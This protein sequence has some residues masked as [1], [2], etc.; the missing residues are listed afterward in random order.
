MLLYHFLLVALFFAGSVNSLPVNIS[1]S[2]EP[3]VIG[4]RDYIPPLGM[5]DESGNPSGFNVELAEALFDYLDIEYEIKV[6]VIDQL[7]R[8]FKDDKLDLIFGVVNSKE[9]EGYMMFGVPYYMMS[10]TIISRCEDSYR[11][12]SELRDKKIFVQNKSWIHDYLKKTEYV[13]NI[14]ILPIDESLDLLAAGEGDAVISNSPGSFQLFAERDDGEYDGLSLF[15]VD[16]EPQKYSFAVHSEDKALLDLINTALYELDKSGVVDQLYTKWFGVS[17]EEGIPRIAWIIIVS[18]VVGLIIVITFLVL[19]RHQVERAIAKWEQLN[20]ELTVLKE[21]A[22]KENRMKS[23]FLANIS[24]DIRSPL[25]SIVGFSELLSE[26]DDYNERMRYF[27]I[28][29]DSNDLIIQLIND[30]LDLAKIE[31]GTMEFNFTDVNLNNLLEDFESCSRIKVGNKKINIR[32]EKEQTQLVIS[33]DK[34]R[35]IQV[36][37]NLMS[38][39]IKNTETG[40]ITFGYELKNDSV[41]YY[42]S[43]TGVGIPVDKIG[44]IFERYTKLDNFQQGSGLGLSICYNIVKWF[45]G[46]IGVD[47][48]PGKGSVFWFTIPFSKSPVI[49]CEKINTN[50]S[51]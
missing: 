44:L 27:Q 39:A 11:K 46:E 9:R 34:N 25:N 10:W 35:L 19:L 24:H 45:D 21:K 14:I 49:K 32:F 43:D 2:S 22:E 1:D 5:L 15:N 7:L 16:L 26:S 38:N 50:A 13:D 12:M 47:S 3:V 17:R 37:S 31:A 36:F 20:K 4:I 42:V 48:E 8:D 40:A 51:E 6:A 33:M 23:Q 28:I 18:L 30:L 41:Y 29:Q